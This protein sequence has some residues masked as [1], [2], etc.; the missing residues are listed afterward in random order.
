MS[1]ILLN[2]GDLS[3][4]LDGCGEVKEIYFPGNNCNN[5]V[6]GG[7]LRHKIGIYVD[8]AIHW[9]DD[10]AWRVEQKYYPG[11]L[12]GQT[13]ANN[14]WLGIRLEI[15]D[16]VDS[17]LNVLSRNIN[18][19]NL[20]KR[21]KSVKLFMHQAFV[22]NGNSG[23][24]DTAQYVPA[25]ASKSFDGNMIIHYGEGVAVALT[26]SDGDDN[27]F[28]DYSIG[29]FGENNGVMYDGVWCDA[30]DGALAKNSTDN[31]HVDS[32]V[33]ISAELRCQ[34][35]ARVSYQLA[36][37]ISPREAVKALTRFC[38]EG[39]SARLDK[40]SEHYKNWLGSAFVQIRSK[41]PESYRWPV[42]D[43]L[44][45]LRANTSTEG[46]IV[47]GVALDG[48]TPV[49]EPTR[50]AMIADVLS[51]ASLEVDSARIFDFLMKAADGGL[52]YPAYLA[53]GATAP[54]AYHYRDDRLESAVSEPVDLADTAIVLYCLAQSVMRGLASKQ[55]TNQWKKLWLHHGVNLAN[56]LADNIDAITKLPKASWHPGDKHRQARTVDIASTYGAFVAAAQVC[57]T[58]KDLDGVIK[59]SA[60][61]DDIAAS[62]DLLWNEGRG[63]FYRGYSRT[64][65]DYDYDG[66][67]DT[68]ALLTCRIF[69]LMEDKFDVAESTLVRL[70]INNNGTYMRGENDISTDSLSVA[71]VMTLSL[72]MG[73]YSGSD[74]SRLMRACD[75]M[76]RAANLPI[77]L[78]N[79]AA[80]LPLLRAVFV[81]INLD[82]VRQLA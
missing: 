3:V 30:A 80:N 44:A 9:L 39:A 50:A 40:T 38:H 37:G 43:A 72:L 10:G 15:Q 61:A 21:S 18:I 13:I 4:G 1:R 20:T 73:K 28:G 34:D 17:E 78:P 51:R 70:H 41:V 66:R 31:G 29:K 77:S 64:G 19:I 69:G 27:S 75:K 14:R 24:A 11:S 81:D 60:I 42:V 65:D 32:I 82:Q 47:T 68:V 2:N 74:T 16:F 76:L 26:A 6:G 71:D 22:L 67:I 58:L 48:R 53:S 35:S 79:A 63:F 62:S 7:S 49:V 56:C 46:A 5:H 52:L 45:T 57:D 36:L 25:G 33:G 54:N 55:L 23:A 59:Y 8:G 12:V